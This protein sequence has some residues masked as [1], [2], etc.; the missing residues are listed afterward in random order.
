M[1]CII[2]RHGL[3]L[4]GPQN[5]TLGWLIKGVLRCNGSFLLQILSS[6]GSEKCATLEWFLPSR[7]FTLGSLTKVMLHWKG[8]FLPSFFPSFVFFLPWVLELIVFIFVFTCPMSYEETILVQK[9]FPCMPHACL[10]GSHMLD[11]KNTTLIDGGWTLCLPEKNK[12]RPSE[13]TCSSSTTDLWLTSKVQKACT[14]ISHHCPTLTIN[15]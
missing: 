5:C 7:N 11:T 3:A 8:C 1:R 10:S 9:I 2:S 4:L 6:I 12:G 14:V 13:S 15:S